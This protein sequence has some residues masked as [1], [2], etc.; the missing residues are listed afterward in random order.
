MYAVLL[1]GG[2]QHRVKEGQIIRLE[3]INLK[4]GKTIEFKEILMISDKKNIKIGN[5]ILSQSLI[6]AYIENHGKHK[7]IKILKFNRRK[8]YKK[9]QGHRQLFTDVKIT[10]IITN[11]EEFN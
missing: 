5:P 2:K 1:N 8:H 11:T 3:K 9:T 6:Q 7:K 4:I 10:K